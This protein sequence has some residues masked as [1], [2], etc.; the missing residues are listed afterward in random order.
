MQFPTER[1]TGFRVSGYP[2]VVAAAA[3]NSAMKL[4]LVIVWRRNML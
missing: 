3:A 1:E 2:A 4:R